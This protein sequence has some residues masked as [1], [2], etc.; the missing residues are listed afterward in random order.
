VNS[1]FEYI[2]AVVNRFTNNALTD[3]LG[4]RGST[5]DSPRVGVSFREV[6]HIKALVSGSI[7]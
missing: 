2:V 5:S 1:L 6:W 7:C 4:I 3:K